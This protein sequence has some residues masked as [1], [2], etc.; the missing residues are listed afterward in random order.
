MW[1]WSREFSTAALSLLCYGLVDAIWR[2]PPPHFGL[3]CRTY[4]QIQ[5][6]YCLPE[7]QWLTTGSTWNDCTV[8]PL[9]P[10]QATGGVQGEKSS[11]PVISSILS[12]KAREIAISPACFVTGS[13]A[14]FPSSSQPS[15]KQIWTCFVLS[16]MV[17]DGG[18]YLR[19]WDG[20]QP[21]AQSGC[22]VRAY[23]FQQPGSCWVRKQSRIQWMLMCSCVDRNT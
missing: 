18:S 14:F 13:I 12:S 21:N 4:G 11:S 15:A 8:K 7:L 17:E 6:S 3:A 10:P 5:L 19:G 1:Q 22:L 16:L 2:P 9:T 20:L 23:Q